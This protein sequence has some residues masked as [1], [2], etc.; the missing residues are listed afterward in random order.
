MSAELTKALTSRRTVYKLTEYVTGFQ[1]SLSC[2]LK[3]SLFQ[4]HSKSSI[5]DEKIREI[6]EQG[7]E[8]CSMPP[9]ILRLKRVSLVLH[10]PTSFNNQAIRAVVLLKEQCVPLTAWKQKT[11]VDSLFLQTQKALGYCRRG[12]C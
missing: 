5:A 11:L 8:L 9:P 12:S 6:V 2:I 7:G 4:P 3:A 1:L 10:T